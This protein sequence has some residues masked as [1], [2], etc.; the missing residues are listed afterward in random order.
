MYATRDSTAFAQRSLTWSHIAVITEVFCPRLPPQTRR[1][2]VARKDR[3]T[4]RRRPPVTGINTQSFQRAPRFV[5]RGVFQGIRAGRV[6]V[7]VTYCAVVA[8]SPCRTSSTYPVVARSARANLSTEGAAE[9]DRGR[10]VSKCGAMRLRK[11]QNRDLST[12]Y[13]TLKV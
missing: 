1:C 3:V 10:F 9:V 5:G 7:S 11:D 8:V 12:V 6:E 2:I 4:F 13:P